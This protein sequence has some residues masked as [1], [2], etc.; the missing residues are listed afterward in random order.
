MDFLE[1]QQQLPGQVATFF[2]SDVPRLEL[3][4]SCYMYGVPDDTIQ[5]IS[6]PIGLIFVDDEKLENLPKII[7]ENLHLDG[8]TAAGLAYEINKR[9]FNL[10]P[11]YFIDSQRLLDEWAKQK[12]TPIL[13]EDDA[14]QKVLEVEPWIAE[15]EREKRQEARIAQEEKATVEKLS[16]SAALQKYPEINEQLVT[17]NRI[18]LNSFPEP[19]RPS[20]KN[21]LSDYTFTIGF[22]PHNSAARGIYLFQNQNTRNLNRQDQT[23]LS[24]ILR[25]FDTNETVDINTTLKQIIFP[26]FVPAEPT[27]KPPVA[28]PKQNF[29]NTP[30]PEKD[31]FR[32]NVFAPNTLAKPSLSGTFTISRKN[33]TAPAAKVDTRSTPT[34]PSIPS[35]S[36]EKMLPVAPS[37]LPLSAPKN[38][39]TKKTFL[40]FSSPQRLPFEN[41]SLPKEKTVLPETPAGPAPLKIVPRNFHPKTTSPN[42]PSRN[43][44]NLK[45]K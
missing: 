29:F 13:T 32:R 39:T 42:A 40:Q 26:R 33:P 41:Q 18:S 3:E 36:N 30:L 12:S 14:W 20:I 24:H 21:W 7:L 9:I 44:V 34:T 28:A 2:N 8:S 25:A 16:L 11:E 45:E 17:S 5:N 15:E 27:P 22:D 6:G 35:L 4:R 19:V 43:V 31:T 10:F 1:K 37:N 23:N 38:T